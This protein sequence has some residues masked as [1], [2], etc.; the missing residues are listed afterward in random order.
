MVI[1]E[2]IERYWES[3]LKRTQGQED[4]F[5]RIGAEGYWKKFIKNMMRCN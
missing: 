2:Q 4:I 3:K 5:D 1:K